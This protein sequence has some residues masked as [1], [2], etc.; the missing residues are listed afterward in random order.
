MRRLLA[1]AAL[2]AIPLLVPSSGVAAK[3]VTCQVPAFPT[4]A[5]AFDSL[6]AKIVSCKTAQSVAVAYQKCRLKNGPKG[7]CV[8]Y[9]NK[10]WACGEERE[11]TDTS[12]SARARCLRKIGKPVH[13]KY[14]TVYGVYFTYHQT[15]S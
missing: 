3:K 6:Q 10:Y 13:G 1:V 9:V 5:G 7:R 11:G 2:A 8:K 4:P 15:T 12:F 14:K